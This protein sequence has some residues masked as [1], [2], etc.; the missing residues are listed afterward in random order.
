MVKDEE[1]RFALDVLNDHRRLI[2][3][4]KTHRWDIVK[5]AVTI[6]VTLAGA[7]VTLVK[8][9]QTESHMTLS[10][11]L[12]FL[13]IAAVVFM[14]A[15]WLMWEV[16]R[17]MTAARNDARTTLI[18]LAGKQIDIRAVTGREVPPKPYDKSYDRQESRIYIAIVLASVVPAFAVWL[19]FR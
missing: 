11:Q 10:P 7:S 1:M 9:Q 18:Y 3:A 8:L 5:W 19:L 12:M 4:G 15:V 2:A 13:W 16:T 14:L 6:N 17:R